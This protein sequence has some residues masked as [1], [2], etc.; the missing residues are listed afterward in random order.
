MDLYVFQFFFF[1]VSNILGIA[2][3]AGIF[4]ELEKYLVNNQSH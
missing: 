2:E 3:D 1:L 4:I